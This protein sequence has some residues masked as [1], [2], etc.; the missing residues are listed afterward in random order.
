MDLFAAMKRATEE[1]LE[2]LSS[3]EEINQGSCDWWV[4]LV[5]RYLDDAAD[6]VGWWI[7]QDN[8]LTEEEAFDFSHCV[9][10]YEGKFYDCLRPQGVEDPLFLAYT[11]KAPAGKE[12]EYQEY[13]SWVG[14]ITKR[15]KPPCLWDSLNSYRG[16]IL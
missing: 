10:W 12:K 9:L 13:V 5:L 2:G 8:R 15:G 7:D 14:E 11:D 1:T 4:D 3:I 6:V 16:Q